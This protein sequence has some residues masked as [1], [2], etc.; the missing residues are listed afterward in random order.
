MFPPNIYYSAILMAAGVIC[1]VV[2]VVIWFLRREAVAARSLTF[3]LL[4]LSWWDITYSIFWMDFPGPTP[5]FWLDLTLVG[6]FIV[7]TAFLIF[8]LEYSNRQQLLRRHVILAL[9]IEPVLTFILLWTDPLHD[10]FFGGK[11]ALNT[12]M[13]LDAGPVSWANVYYSYLL[14]LAGIVILFIAFYRANGVYRIQAGLILVAIIF[15][16]LIHIGY[17]T[18]GGLLPNADITPFIFSVTAVVVAFALVRY[19]LLDITPIARGVLIESMNEGVLVLDSLN[20]IVDFNPTAQA[21]LSTDFSIGE[22]IERAFVHWSDFISHFFDE[23]QAN[24]EISIDDRYLD[25]RI[26]PLRDKRNRLVGKLVVWRD[27]TDL[28]NIQLKFEKLAMTDELTLAYNRRHFMGLAEAQINKSRRYG[29]PLSLALMDL[30]HFKNINDNYGHSI[31]DKVLAGFASRLREKIRDFDVFARLGGEE[32]ALIMPETDIE[33]AYQVTERLRQSIAGS[34]LDLG[35]GHLLSITFSLG[36][37]DFKGGQD[38][39]GSMLRRA[40]HAL[41]AAKNAGRNC[42]FVWDETTVTKAEP[43]AKLT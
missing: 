9:L 38:T 25:I 1:L 2:A 8:A 21:A 24:A 28:K 14:I 41:Y 10:L 31:G 19:R 11:R 34:P 16:W 40:D 7:P 22:S 15:P 27:I 20:R 33:K 30:D 23:E 4:G 3:F 42:T 5:Y 43:P 6:A 18:T 12:T 35:D 13:I 17:M 36:L 29:Q 39:L 26:S 37:T 32:F